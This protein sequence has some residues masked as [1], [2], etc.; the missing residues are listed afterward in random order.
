MPTPNFR[1]HIFGFRRRMSPKAPQAS[2]FGKTAVFS[3]SMRSFAPT[4][5]MARSRYGGIRQ[6]HQGVFCLHLFFTLE[7]GIIIAPTSLYGTKGVFPD[8]SR[9]LPP[10]VLVPDLVGIEHPR[11]VVDER[12]LKNAS[13]YGPALSVLVRRG[14]YL[15]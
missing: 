3:R 8:A 14:R 4:M 6:K 11:A 13:F 5:L 9:D 2:V 12:V 10:L 7:Q 1:P 15:L